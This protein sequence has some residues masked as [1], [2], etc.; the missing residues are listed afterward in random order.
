VGA[1]AVVTAVPV[2]EFLLLG[3]IS[4]TG[5]GGPGR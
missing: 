2:S 5:A 1:A 4:D 3:T